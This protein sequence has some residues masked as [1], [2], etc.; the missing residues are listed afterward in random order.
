MPLKKKNIYGFDPRLVIAAISFSITNV[1]RLILTNQ[2][3]TVKNLNG[4]DPHP[5]NADDNTRNCSSLSARVR[6][7]LRNVLISP[8]V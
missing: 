7:Y 1:T 6:D 8:G 2:C 5:V 3:K 4:C